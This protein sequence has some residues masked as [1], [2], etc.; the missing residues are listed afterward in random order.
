MTSRHITILL[1]ERMLDDDDWDPVED[2]L[3]L[4][5]ELDGTDPST[6]HGYEVGLT[7]SY[8]EDDVGPVDVEGSTFDIYGGYRH[9]FRPDPA[10]HPY[11]S[12]GLAWIFGEVELD[13]PGP[14]PDDDDSSLGAYVRAGIGF[15][16][17]ERTRLG[18]DYRHLFLS[19]VDILGIDDIDFDQLA[20]TLGFAF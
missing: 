3:A 15:D 14:T 12:A 2:Q 18:I 9:T 19:D 20:L 13:G 7:S 16:L 6:G 10:V 1:G 8:D 5:V 4:G 17:N 11:L